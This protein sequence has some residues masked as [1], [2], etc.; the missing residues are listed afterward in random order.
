MRIIG[1]KHG[2]V[3]LNQPFFE[4]TRPTT[5]LAKEA[6]FNMIDNY[7]NFENITFLDLFGGSGSISYEFGSR[8]TN[9]ITTVEIYPKCLDFIRKTSTILKLEQHKIVPMDV[10]QFIENSKQSYDIIF[11]GPPYKM[12]RLKELPDLIIEKKMIQD[13]GWFILEHDPNYNF[14]KHPHFWK[15]KKYGQ[16]NFSIF[17]N[18]KSEV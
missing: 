15:R 7:F 2:G 12:S 13:E 8:G 5:D 4:P 11:A 10:F 3:F 16:T 17:I 14:D 6:L 18:K 9:D 1:G